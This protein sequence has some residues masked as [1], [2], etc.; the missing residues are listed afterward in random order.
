MLSP[1]AINI[2]RPCADV[3]FAEGIRQREYFE[4]TQFFRRLACLLLGQRHRL[5]FGVEFEVFCRA[6]CDAGWDEIAGFIT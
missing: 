6:V 5:A 1:A 3:L 4:S 2:G